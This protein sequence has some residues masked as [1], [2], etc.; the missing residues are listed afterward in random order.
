MR[1]FL[2]SAALLLSV[3]AACAQAPGAPGKAPSTSDLSGNERLL[4]ATPPGWQPGATQRTEKGVTS[5]VYPPG[6][7]PD[8]WSDMLVVQVFPGHQGSPR[9]YVEMVIE[10]SR[11][12]CEAI[13]P[14]PVTERSL[15]GYPA[16]ALTVS[17]TRGLR[18][19][20][21]G[22]V[23]VQAIRGREAL[24]VVQRLWQGPAFARNDAVPVPQETLKEWGAFARTVG[25]CDM[26]NPKNPCP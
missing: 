20:K 6:Q 26:T 11:S 25:L 3:S 8:N 14:S 16:A 9:Q 12:T 19:G 15:N 2:L 1:L 10:T 18:T 24:Y 17:C 4:M 21:G 22:L 23:M 7:K 5:M 13:G